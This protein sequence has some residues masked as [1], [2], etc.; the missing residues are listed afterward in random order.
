MIA[1]AITCLIVEGVVCGLFFFAGLEKSIDRQQF[2]NVLLQVPVIPF[3]A[4]APLS[5]L[6]PAIEVVA[7]VVAVAFSCPA[8]LAMMGILNLGFAVGLFFMLRKKRLV[9]CSCFGDLSPRPI[10]W[11]NIYFNLCLAITL[12]L[13]LA[14]EASQQHFSLRVMFTSIGLGII[15]LGFSLLRLFKFGRH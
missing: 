10:S 5:V 8:A 4:I 3:W 14:W 2:F 7:A 9:P 12:L 13:L 1:V 15:A 6:I 11:K